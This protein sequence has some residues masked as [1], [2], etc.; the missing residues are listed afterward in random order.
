MGRISIPYT[1]LVLSS[2]L[3]LTSASH[4]FQ[5]TS[6]SIAKRSIALLPPSQDPFYT[7]PPGYE[8]A[9]PGAVLRVRSARGLTQVIPNCTDAYNILYRT[10]DSNY[11]PAWAVTTLYIPQTGST[12]STTNSTTGASGSNLLSYQEAC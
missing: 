12:N 4:G 10:T 8:N 5:K 1:L 7:A 6:P 9:A 2:M 11:Q 3:W